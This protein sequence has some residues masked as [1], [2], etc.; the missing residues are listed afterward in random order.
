[1][2]SFNRGPVEVVGADAPATDKGQ[3]I[4]T[5]TGQAANLISSIF[6]PKQTAA[7]SGGTTPAWLLPVIVGGI[8]VVAVTILAGKKK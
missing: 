3:I 5:I 6:A 1:M 4:T 7:P 8:G 2:A